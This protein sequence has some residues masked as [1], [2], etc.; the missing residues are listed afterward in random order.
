M[1]KNLIHWA[2]HSRLVVVLLALALLA[3]GLYSFQPRER[4]GLSRPG[5]ADRRG[6]RPVSRGLG[7]GSGAAGDDP[8]GGDLAGMP[9]LKYTRSKSL[10]ELSPHPQPVRVRRRSAG[11]P[12]GGDQPP[13]VRAACPPGSCRRSRPNRPPARSSA[14]RCAI[15]RTPQGRPIYS[16]NDLKSL[17]DYTLERQFR[18]VP[19]IA[20][21]VS[22]GGTVKRYEIHPDPARH[23][24]LRHHAS[25]AQGRRHRQQR[26]RRRA[27]R[28]SR[29]RRCRSSAAWA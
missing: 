28:R 5:P 15:R 14:T 26:Q 18:R 9:G 16:L 17:Q 1:I 24:A 12:A 13:A 10:F 6:H 2:V 22:F 20:D 7:R 4:R 29:A 21:V 27:V 25:A 3:F 11:R 23:A 8:A 19:R